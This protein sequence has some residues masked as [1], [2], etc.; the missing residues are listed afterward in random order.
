M[1]NKFNHFKNKRFLEGSTKVFSLS[2]VM[3]FLKS[4]GSLL[5]S[6]EE[7]LTSRAFPMQKGAQTLGK[8]K[9]FFTLGKMGL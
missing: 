7:P 1:S 3:V 4:N 6:V 5:A 2:K 9:I 8:G